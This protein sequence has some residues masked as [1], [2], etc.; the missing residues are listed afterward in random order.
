MPP[1]VPP[2]LNCPSPVV[3]PGVPPVLLI[4]AYGL[5]ILP[6]IVMPGPSIALR[7]SAPF[8]ELLMNLR[9]QVASQSLGIER[10]FAP[11]MPGF[12]FNGIGMLPLAWLNH[13]GHSDRE[14]RRRVRNSE[15]H[16]QT[17]VLSDVPPDR[18]VRRIARHAKRLRVVS[19]HIKRF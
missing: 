10:T 6:V 14:R 8:S 2:L 17:I 13:R 9:N 15:L 7:T 16:H 19:R 1:N 11:L 3:P 5:E 18:S 12:V 4:V